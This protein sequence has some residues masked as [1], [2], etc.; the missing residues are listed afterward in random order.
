MAFMILI[1]IEKK[2]SS[3]LFITLVFLFVLYVDFFYTFE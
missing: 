2:G 3:T 1:C